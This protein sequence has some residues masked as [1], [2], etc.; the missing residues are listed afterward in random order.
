LLLLLAVLLPVRGAVAAAMLCSI[1]GSGTQVELR[2]Q[3]SAHH[4]MD[5]AMA[6]SD[7]LAHDH[8]NAHRGHLGEQHDHSDGGQPDKCNVCSAFGS[9]TPL[10]SAAPTVLSPLEATK[11]VFSTLSAPAP[12]FFSDG[13]ERPPRS[14]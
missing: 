3:Q 9:M 11:A 13:P 12:S 4:S 6:A 14:I 5:R 1:A 8:A 2:L 10:L 7:H